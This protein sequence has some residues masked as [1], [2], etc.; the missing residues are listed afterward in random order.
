MVVRSVRSG[1]L[2]TNPDPAE[3]DGIAI[4]AVPTQRRSVASRQKL[5]EIAMR[6]F[7]EDGVRA[8]RIEDIVGEAGVAWG[9]FFHYFPRKE[10]LLLFAAAEHFRA[11]VRPAFEEGIAQPDWSARLVTREVLAQVMIPRYSPSLHAEILA[12]MVRHP[13][14]FVAI[15]GEGDL[16]IIVLISRLLAEGQERGEVRADVDPFEAAVVI[17]AGVLFSNNRILHAVAAGHLPGDEIAAMA[18][19]ALD[20]AW[21]GVQPAGG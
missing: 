16:P 2:V 18:D 1:Q 8:T 5:F 7:E 11:Y 9:T 6:R 15:L 14:R 4:G 13:P 19:R 10:D 21:A 12:E 17:G 3:I 20:I